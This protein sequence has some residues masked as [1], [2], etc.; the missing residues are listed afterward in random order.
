MAFDSLLHQRIID[1]QASS[2][3]IAKHCC[4]DASKLHKFRMSNPPFQQSSEAFRLIADGLNIWWD[5]S[6]DNS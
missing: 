6:K 5:W 3:F 2:K 1:L 4:R